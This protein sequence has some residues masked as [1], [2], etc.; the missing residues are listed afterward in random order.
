MKDVTV[1]FSCGHSR[2]IREDK[3]EDFLVWWMNKGANKTPGEGYCLECE[4]IG[5]EKY[6]KIVKVK[7]V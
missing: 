2:K 3:I 4:K 5:E 7:K 6:R 1:F